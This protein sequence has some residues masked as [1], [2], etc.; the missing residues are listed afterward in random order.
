MNHYSSVLVSNAKGQPDN[1]NGQFSILQTTGEEVM[2]ENEHLIA[3][4]STR[5]GLLHHVTTK[6]DNIKSRV[7]E[8]TQ[9]NRF[10]GNF[11][12]RF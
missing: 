2:L 7:C 12:N 5:S 4:F 3:H 9:R 8:V 6:A 10:P 11:S 1:H